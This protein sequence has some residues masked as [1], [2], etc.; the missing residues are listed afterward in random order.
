[1][2]TQL[3]NQILTFEASSVCGPGG[4]NMTHMAIIST[5]QQVNIILSRVKTMTYT[6]PHNI[7]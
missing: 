6:R 2:P 3:F 5:T 4:Y 7:D 1:M